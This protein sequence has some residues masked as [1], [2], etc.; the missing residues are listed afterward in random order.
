[1]NF[2]TLKKLIIMLPV[3]SDCATTP[4]PDHI[5]DA[6]RSHRDEFRY[7]YERE[8]NSKD[9]PGAGKVSLIWIINT[10]GHA[11]NVKV[12]ESTLKNQKVEECLVNVT[13]RIQF[14]KPKEPT[15]IK[16]PFAFSG[17]KN[18]SAQ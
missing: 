6:I 9:P 4:T 3:F 7:C 18:V 11:Q 14:P 16:Y 10:S 5:D 15:T 13:R 17:T 1:M 2:K 12:S 8:L